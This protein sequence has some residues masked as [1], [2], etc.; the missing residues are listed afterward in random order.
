VASE[1]LDRLGLRRLCLRRLRPDLNP[2]PTLRPPPPLPL[3][4]P[5]P[6][7]HPHPYRPH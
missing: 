2:Y 6:H 7:P 3:P 5:H 4:H 1:Y